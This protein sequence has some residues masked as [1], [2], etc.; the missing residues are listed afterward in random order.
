MEKWVDQDTAVIADSIYCD[1]KLVARDTP[2]TLPEITFLTAEVNAMG[3]MSA[4][5]LGLIEDM[6]T[7]ITKR[8]VDK[9][10]FTMLTPGAHDYEIRF[11]Q[12]RMSAD[13]R[14]RAVGCKA[15]IT[16]EA[17]TIPGIGLEV[18]SQSENETTITTTRYL[19]Y[20]DGEEM[21]CI[22]RL[23]GICRILGVDHYKKIEEHL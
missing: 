13:G 23:A 20:V 1:D 19:L 4:A 2:V 11:V 14:T 5:I 17:N 15:F 9:N 6:I 12:N 22:D 3:T 10:F 21:L 16:G 18:G 8:G 7:S